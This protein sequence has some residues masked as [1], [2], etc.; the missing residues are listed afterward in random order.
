MLIKKTYGFFE[1][2]LQKSLL[3]IFVTVH[4][5]HLKRCFKSKKLRFFVQ[6]TKGSFKTYGFL[7]EGVR[8]ANLRFSF[9]NC[10]QCEEGKRFKRRSGV[11]VKQGANVSSSASKIQI[12][13][14]FFKKF[15][16]EGTP[17]ALALN[18][19]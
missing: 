15:N 18:L 5:W 1:R 8:R 3:P 10:L 19:K 9:L 11:I 6:R 16:K 2:T 7:T 12:V 14:F 4:A 13:E 17:T